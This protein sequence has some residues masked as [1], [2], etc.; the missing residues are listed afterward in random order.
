M[1]RALSAAP[2]QVAKT[3]NAHSVAAGARGVLLNGISG[4]GASIVCGIIVKKRC[5]SNSS[6]RCNNSSNELQQDLG[7]RVT[8]NFNTI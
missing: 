6:N 5:A 7:K 3:G 4:S 1:K 8:V 2:K